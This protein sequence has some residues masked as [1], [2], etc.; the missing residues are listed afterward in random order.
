MKVT[1]KKLL[2]IIVGLVVVVVLSFVAFVAWSLYP[3][4]NPQP[5]PSALVAFDSP[6][7]VKR[8]ENAAALADF[9]RLSDS[10]Q[11]QSL[12]SYC[13]VA[14]SVSVLSALGTETSQRTFF[15][16]E[17]SQVRSRFKVMFGGMSLAELAGL[18][19][20]YELQATV[21]HADEFTL[22]EFRSI[23]ELN[24]STSG[25][26]LLVNYQREELGQGRAGHI[27]PLAAYDRDSDSILVLDTAAHKYPPTWV[28]LELLYAAMK[29]TDGSSGKMRGLVEVSLSQ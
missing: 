28:P 11:A 20:A 15:T 6:E 8:H 18:L 5:L 13:G 12:A 26:Y 25:D 2:K 24:L 23:V 27:S 4:T 21:R 29:T 1:L 9:E 14:S 7:G 17:A 19:N 10:F 16:N 3:H 22:A